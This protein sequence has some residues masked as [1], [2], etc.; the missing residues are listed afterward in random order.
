M[1]ERI[2]RIRRI[3]TDFSCFFCSDFENQ[4]KKKIRPYPP[5]PPNPFSHRITLFQNG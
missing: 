2:G 4:A 1:G 3:E 5:D